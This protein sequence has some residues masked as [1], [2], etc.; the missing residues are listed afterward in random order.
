MGVRSLAHPLSDSPIYWRQRRDEAIRQLVEA[1]RELEGAES[2]AAL[3]DEVLRALGVARL[4]A[5]R[6]QPSE[7]SASVEDARP[8]AD[9][10]AGRAS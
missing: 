8:A 4:R 5:A 7:T 6:T 1:V 9:T 10:R 2:S 3:E